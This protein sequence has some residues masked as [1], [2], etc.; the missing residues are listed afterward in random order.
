[1][2]RQKRS[3]GNATPPDSPSISF[4]WMY[5]LGRSQGRGWNASLPAHAAHRPLPVLKHYFFAAALSEAAAVGVADVSRE[6]DGLGK[7][8]S[9]L[10]GRMGV[11]AE[12]DWDPFLVSELENF[13]AGINFFAI[14]AQASGV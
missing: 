11:G 7:I 8:Q 10:A 6:L 4:R 3:K 13:S 12:C 5:A 14:F 2:H 1:M 9:D